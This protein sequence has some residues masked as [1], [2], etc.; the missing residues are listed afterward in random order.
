MMTQ[1]QS[2]PVLLVHESGLQPAGEPLNAG[3]IQH[4]DN[5][6]GGGAVKFL[7]TSTLA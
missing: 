1:P 5:L 3:F 2:L 6:C 7:K 4:P